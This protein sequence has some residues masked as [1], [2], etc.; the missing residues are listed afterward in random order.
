MPLNWVQVLLRPQRAA[1][2][3]SGQAGEEAGT[4]GGDQDPGCQ[5]QPQARERRRTIQEKAPRQS[6]RQ[7]QREERGVLPILLPATSFP[8]TIPRCYL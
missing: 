6:H 7:G 1:H 8:S 2:G 3:G 5:Q 4:Q